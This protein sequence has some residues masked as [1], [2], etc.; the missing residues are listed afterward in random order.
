MNFIN[1]NFD[2]VNSVDEFKN[3]LNYFIKNKSMVSIFLLKL[4]IKK[5]MRLRVQLPPSPPYKYLKVNS[6]G[7]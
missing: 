3:I 1:N 7:Y 5:L 4:L 6:L 2:S